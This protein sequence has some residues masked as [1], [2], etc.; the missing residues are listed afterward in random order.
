M[1]KVYSTCTHSRPARKAV[2]G[3]AFWALTELSLKSLGEHTQ[4]RIQALKVVQKSHQTNKQQQTLARGEESDLHSCHIVISK[5]SNF[6][7]KNYEAC[8]ETKKYGPY[9]GKRN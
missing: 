1:L 9:I 8:K 7:M 3:V 6:S 2:V 5:M 4:Q